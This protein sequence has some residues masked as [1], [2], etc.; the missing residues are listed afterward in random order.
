MWRMEDPRFGLI[1]FAWRAAHLKLARSLI[2]VAYQ[3]GQNVSRWRGIR[4]RG[5]VFSSPSAFRSRRHDGSFRDCGHIHL[6]YELKLVGHDATRLPGFSSAPRS[7]RR[8]GVRFAESPTPIP[9]LP[10]M[11]DIVAQ[12]REPFVRRPI[13]FAG[14]VADWPFLAVDHGIDRH[15]IKMKGDAPSWAVRRPT[16]P[17]GSRNGCRRLTPTCSR[18][19]LTVDLPSRSTETATTSTSRGSTNC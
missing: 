15:S 13:D 14:D 19:A 10:S 16:L 3:F 18:N 2:Q 17:L 11:S 1:S 8:W 9:R 4:M 6:W 5:Q 7:K 12:K